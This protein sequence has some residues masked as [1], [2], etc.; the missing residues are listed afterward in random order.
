MVNEDILRFGVN[1]YKDA[2][3]KAKDMITAAK[4]YS[5]DAVKILEKV[6]KEEGLE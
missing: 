6:I 2:G 5:Y 3:F 4:V 1:A